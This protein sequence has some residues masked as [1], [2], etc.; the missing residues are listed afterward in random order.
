MALNLLSRQT[1]AIAPMRKMVVSNDL[2]MLCRRA[3]TSKKFDCLQAN[4]FSMFT[5]SKVVPPPRPDVNA[6]SLLAAHH[7]FGDFE[8]N[9]DESEFIF[10]QDLLSKEWTGRGLAAL[11]LDES[12]DDWTMSIDTPGMTLDDISIHAQN[13][14]ITVSGDRKVERPDVEHGYYERTFGKFTRSFTLGPHSAP[15]SINATLEDGVLKINVQKKVLSE[16]ELDKEEYQ[17]PVEVIYGQYDRNK[18]EGKQERKQERE[19]QRKQ[20]MFDRERHLDWD[21]G[22]P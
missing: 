2:S 12:D 10:G 20:R 4:D 9:K 22:Q 6:Y 21:S 5:R 3:I 19:Q 13:S 14:T 8:I 18:Q 16:H 17:V 11:D 7:E 1:L 15:L